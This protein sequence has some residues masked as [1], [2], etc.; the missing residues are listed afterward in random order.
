MYNICHYIFIILFISICITRACYLCKT[1]LV[2]LL[3]HINTLK[4]YTI[5]WQEIKKN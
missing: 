1:I 5:F 4:Y 3:K 2:L